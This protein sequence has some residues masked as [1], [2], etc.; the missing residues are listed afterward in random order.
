MHQSCYSRSAKNGA[1]FVW[2][3]EE[4]WC[5]Q[6]T[7]LQRRSYLSVNFPLFMGSS[8]EHV[9]NVQ[10]AMILTKRVL[11]VYAFIT[12]NCK[13]L[14]FFFVCFFNRRINRICLLFLQLHKHHIWHGEGKTNGDFEEDQLFLH[15]DWCANW[16]RTTE[17]ELIYVRFLG[18][19]GPVNAYLFRM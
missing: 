18:E 16:C 3:N 7:T 13:L 4:H 15:Y 12:N 6:P 1:G 2:K 10:T 11:G 8:K 9:E 5:T 17:N 14:C 19:K